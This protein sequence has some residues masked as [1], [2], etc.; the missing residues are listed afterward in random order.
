MRI[1]LARHGETKWSRSG[2]HTGTTDLPLT[3]EGERQAAALGARLGGQEFDL[4]VSSPASR[5]VATAKAVG[6]PFETDDRLV[7]LD[8][9][10]YEGLTTVQIRGRVPSWDLWYEGC[11]GGETVEEVGERCDAVLQRL[12]ES[13]AKHVLLFG[14][15]HTFRIFTARYLGLDAKIGRLF[16]LD[17]ATLSELG[18]YHARPVVVTWNSGE[19]LLSGA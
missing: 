8:Y 18:E 4:V 19:H 7:E 13:G 14:H 11:P 15:S 1:Q 6:L 3:E 10:D 2:Q 12:I 16:K 9:G 17:T 5:A